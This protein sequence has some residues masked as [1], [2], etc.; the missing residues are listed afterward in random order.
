[1][2]THIGGLDSVAE[3][4]L[5]LPQIP[6]GKKLI[7]TNISMELTALEEFETKGKTDPLFAEL[8]KI[9]ARTKGLWSVEA[10]KYL[11]DHATPI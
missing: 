10:E 9:I 3:T 2:V 11:L 8:A 6:G 5:N 1:M 4:T 7:Y